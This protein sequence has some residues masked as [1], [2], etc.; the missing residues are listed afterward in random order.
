MRICRA[1]HSEESELLP[2]KSALPS[3]KFAHS[4]EA[5]KAKQGIQ[6]VPKFFSLEFHA[7]FFPRLLWA[8]LHRTETERTGFSSILELSVLFAVCLIVAVLGISSGFFHK[9][10][11]GWVAGGLGAAGILALMLNSIFS[12][13]EPPTYDRFLTGVFFFFVILGLTA[14]VLVGTIKRSPPWGLLTGLG[15]LVVGYLLGILAGLW[16]QYLGWLSLLLNGLAGLAVF[17]MLV[18]DLVLL[19]SSVFS[20]GRLVVGL[21]R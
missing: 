12:C 11:I 4:G 18:V 14:G 7:R 21:C 2:V 5:L 9:S 8:H 6:S 17:G 3:R 15:A 16:F 19:A 20:F 1:T 10:V 13:E